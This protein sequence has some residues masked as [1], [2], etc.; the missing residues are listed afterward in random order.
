VSTLDTPT[1]ATSDT[2]KRTA[3]LAATA[4]LIIERGYDG[5]NLDAICER[6][7]CSKTSIYAFFGNKEGLLTALS[8]GIALDLSQAMHALHLQHLSVDEGLCRYARLVLKLIL[9]EKHIAILR[10][11]ISVVWRYPQIGTAYYEV[12]TL[13]AR[14]ALA[15]YFEAKTRDGSLRVSDGASAA[16]AFQGLLLWDHMLAQTVGAGSRLSDTEIEAEADAAVAIF[17]SRYQMPR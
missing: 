14:S 7:A 6:A 9:D 16:R 12:G 15:Q 4:D 17:L 3:I 8:E 5:T 1:T 2:A 10:A 11:T 13:T